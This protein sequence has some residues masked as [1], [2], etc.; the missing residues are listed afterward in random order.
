MTLERR[1]FLYLMLAATITIWGA[2]FVVVDVAIRDGSSPS[3]IAMA[4]FIVASSIF[5]GY[6]IVRRPKG[7][8]KEDRRTFLFL[9]FIGI[10]VYYTF[11]YYGVKLAGA[12]ISSI[13]VMLL[14]PV[15][16][17]AISSWKYKEG[18]TH[19]EKLGLAISGV[20][21]F[22][23]ITDGSLAFASNL[24][25]IIGG[26]FGVVCAVFWAVYTLQGRDVV[27]KYNPMTS[28]AYITILGT[29]MAVPFAVGDA[30]ATGQSFPP[31]FFAAALYLGVLCTVVGY[32]FWYTALTGLDARTTGSVLYF[33]PLVTVVVAWT[34]LGEMIGWVSAIGSI[35]TVVGVVILSRK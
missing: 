14:C 34:V 9:A 26:L 33:E 17:F 21:C 10:G 32:V 7:L 31:S 25:I 29:L 2:S 22:L 11:Q 13:V 20:G 18:V 27:K 35:V 5:L 4:R 12:S 8:A 1:T 28:T 24:D 19:A 6:L 23:V 15:A 30:A 16:I 3:M